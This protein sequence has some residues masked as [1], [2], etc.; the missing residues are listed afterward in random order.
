MITSGR[1]TDLIVQIDGAWR[2]ATRTFTP[3]A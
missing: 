3:D 1:Y 2:F